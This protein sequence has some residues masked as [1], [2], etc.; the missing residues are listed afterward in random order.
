MRCKRTHELYD[1]AMSA[2]EWVIL[3][4]RVLGSLPV[5]RWAL[6]GGVIAVLA[7][8]SDLFL[9]GYL[10]LGGVDNYQSFDKWLD[11][12]YMATFLVA[13]LRWA[14]E[15]RLVAVALYGFR[16]AGFAVFEGT[17][18]RWTL[19]LFPNVFE[20]WFLFVAAMAHARPGL[21]YS[22]RVILSALVPLAVLKELHEY[23]LHGARLFDSFSV[24]DVVNFVASW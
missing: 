17:G 12:V 23:A 20:F 3:A 19:L 1:A 2:E 22:P 14:R 21:R 9:R 8:L 13:A 16:L 24:K 10:E 5:L 11:Q 6:A 4:E 18:A 7:D 15:P